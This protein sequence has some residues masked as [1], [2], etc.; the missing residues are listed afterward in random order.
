MRYFPAPAVKRQ[1]HTRGRRKEAVGSRK[2][3]V[4][5]G[6]LAEGSLP[7]EMRSTSIFQRGR[8]KAVYPVKCEARAYFSGVGKRQFTP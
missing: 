2:L 6:Q 3:A 1:M 4:G 5:N 8:Q 7:R